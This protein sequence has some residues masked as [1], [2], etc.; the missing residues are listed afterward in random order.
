[1]GK[2]RPFILFLGTKLKTSEAE[3][4]NSCHFRVAV[5]LGF[6]VSLGCSNIEREMCLICIRIRN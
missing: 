4:F 5:C 6:E 3:V 1:M 2:N